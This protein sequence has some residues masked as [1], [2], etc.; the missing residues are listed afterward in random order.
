MERDLGMV[1]LYLFRLFQSCKQLGLGK[2][3]GED[4]RVGRELREK[5]SN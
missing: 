3:S 5:I 4:W 1:V 2:Y